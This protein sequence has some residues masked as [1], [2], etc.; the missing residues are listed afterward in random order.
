MEDFEL[1]KGCVSGDKESWN[2]FVEQYTRL[3]YDSIIRT[4]RRFGARIDNDI[5]DDLHND[6]FV[7]L[8]K[9]N[10][11]VLREF[12]GRN[13]CSLASYIRTIGV[14]KTIDYW[15]KQRPTI[16]IDADKDTEEGKKVQFI[17]ELSVFNIFDS[18]E[19]EEAVNIINE[20]F[21]ELKEEERKFCYLC[22]IDGIEPKEAAQQLGISVDN[23]YVRKQRALNKLKKIVK[24]KKI[25]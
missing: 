5:I 16:S 19:K 21:I 8:L 13:G 7:V 14:R 6:I 24:D 12:E 3:I 17:K 18:L 25:C 10:Y 4:F 20:L 23:F 9:D 15:R 1:I 11:R 2:T 22:F